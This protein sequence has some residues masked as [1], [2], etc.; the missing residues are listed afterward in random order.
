[1]PAL[2]ETRERLKVFYSK[3]T[4]YILS[5]LK[6]IAALVVLFM[7]NTQIGSM[8]QLMSPLIVIIAALFCSFMPINTT[9]LVAAVFALAHI[10]NTSLELAIVA[11][12]LFL[13]M[14]LLYCR[15][16]P[17]DAYILLLLPVLFVLKIPYVVPLVAGLLATPVSAVSV[18]C[19]VIV[20]FVIELAKN[21]STI[22]AAAPEDDIV[23]RLQLLLDAIVNNKEMVL[24]II[25]FAATVVI[26]YL[27]R[28]LSVDYA[29]Y[30]AIGVGALSNMII[31][32]AGDFMMDVSNEILP[33]I[34]GT[35]VSVLVCIVVQ[36]L[37]FSVD[38]SGTEHVQYED[39]EYYYYVKAVPK[40]TVSTAKKT[41]RTI[42]EKKPEV[43]RPGTP[44]EYT[45]NRNQLH[46]NS[47]EKK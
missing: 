47:R 2:L 15:F 26:T 3:Y 9:V 37:F 31:L 34:I 43:R 25:A 11:L 44:Y 29:W 13:V 23:A 45:A 8:E 21:S 19:G 32:L 41:V 20:Y 14:F 12:M 24:I 46:N 17:K 42:N 38:Y 7:L 36:F 10:Y 5:V 16:V 40:I 28:R 35:I 39:D 30:I 22:L 1:M 6:F 27:I 18:V 33:M 4:I